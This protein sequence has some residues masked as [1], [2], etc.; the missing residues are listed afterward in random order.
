LDSVWPSG[1]LLIQA[2][3]L[4][5]IADPTMFDETLTKAVTPQEQVTSDTHR[6]VCEMQPR[7]VFTFNYDTAHETAAGQY[8]FEYQLLL[9][10]EGAGKIVEA[11]ATGLMAPFLLKAHGSVGHRAEHLV[12]TAESYREF[13]ARQPTYRAL[14]QHIL[15]EFHLVIVGFGLSDPD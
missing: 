12:L 3:A 5:R 6:A 7:G 13:M 11:L 9:P 1:R 4:L 10:Q 2:A 8:G 15:T 14:V